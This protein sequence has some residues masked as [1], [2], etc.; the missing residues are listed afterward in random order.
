MFYGKN[1]TVESV[2]F[3]EWVTKL[4]N[5]INKRFGSN[6]NTVLF[7]DYKN[8]KDYINYHHDDMY[9]WKK[10]SGVLSLTLGATR[11]F[12]LRLDKTL[13]KQG[14]KTIIPKEH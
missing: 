5:L 14:T 4:V 10:G 12:L 6:F 3:P 1:R 9:N 11:K 7:N 2:L 8:G 13:K